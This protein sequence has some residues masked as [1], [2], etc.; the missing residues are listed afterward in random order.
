MNNS[1]TEILKNMLFALI[2]CGQ[3]VFISDFGFAFVFFCK[4]KHLQMCIKSKKS[5]MVS[6]NDMGIYYEILE[7]CLSLKL[8]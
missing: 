7:D 1:M 2:L 5:N 4:V 3:G 6:P 8:C